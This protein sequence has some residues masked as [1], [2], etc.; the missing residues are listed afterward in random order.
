M[1]SLYD[2]LVYMF[3]FTQDRFVEV[4]LLGRALF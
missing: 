4:E 2:Y 3:T 1:K